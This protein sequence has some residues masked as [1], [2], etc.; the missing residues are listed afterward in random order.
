MRWLIEINVAKLDDGFYIVGTAGKRR[1]RHDRLE[2]VKA[3][4]RIRKRSWKIIEIKLVRM[5]KLVPDVVWH[6][7]GK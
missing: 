3:P 2:L 5:L 7:F 1:N 4:W 6:Y